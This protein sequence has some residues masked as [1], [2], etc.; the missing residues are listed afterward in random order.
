MFGYVK[1]FEP[2]M[3]VCDCETYQSALEG[4]RRVIGKSYGGAAK[5]AVS[6]D[7][8]ML[9]LL[10]VSLSGAETET[11]SIRTIAH[12]FKKTDCMAAG[13]SFDFTAAA[14]V[15]ITYL[16]NLDDLGEKRFLKKLSA[17]IS[18]KAME[19][20]YIKASEQYPELA[21]YVSEQ[22][23]V[24]NKLEKENCKSIDR[25]SEPVSNII[26]KIA[27]ETGQTAEQKRILNRFGYLLG[28]FVYIS[29]AF[30]SLE[31]DFSSRSFNPLVMGNYVVN[32]LDLPEVQKKTED[33]IGFTL[34]SLADCYVQLE[35][36]TFKPI[37]DNIVYLGLK[38]SF[39]DLIK[40]KEEKPED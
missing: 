30:D 13:N 3:R 19:K 32:D 35:F 22:I 24:Q 8:V 18:L 25:A 33:S 28:R 14:G 38:N 36:E 12:P 26:A 27:E 34:G 20:A 15:I 9:G 39:Y 7:F 4:L 6:S 10:A 5:K 29:D 11:V 2:H 1:P 21:E 37:I 17:R 31:K 40:K 16:K 23:R